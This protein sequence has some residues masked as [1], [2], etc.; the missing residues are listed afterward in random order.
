MQSIIEESV[1]WHQERV[2][3]AV[4]VRLGEED[5]ADDGSQVGV[6]AGGPERLEVRDVVCQA[7]YQY[8]QRSWKR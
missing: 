7:I 3:I 6:I 4:G 2:D 1:G 5:E 8:I